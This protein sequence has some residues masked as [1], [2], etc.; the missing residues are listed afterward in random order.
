MTLEA[1]LVFPGQGGGAERQRAVVQWD[2]SAGH[3]LSPAATVLK[4][5]ACG[6]SV[7][8]AALHAVGIGWETLD[9]AFT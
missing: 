1:V 8:Q 5:K 3:P 2:P 7:A 9:P 4:R 6:P